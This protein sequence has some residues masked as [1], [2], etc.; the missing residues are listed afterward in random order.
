M[1]HGSWANDL[2]TAFF[3]AVHKNRDATGIPR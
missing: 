1:P 2:P 3:L